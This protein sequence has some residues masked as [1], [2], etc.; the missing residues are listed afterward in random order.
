M[1]NYTLEQV[2]QSPTRWIYL[3]GRVVGFL[4]A[5][6]SSGQPWEVLPRLG[7]EAF[8]PD[9]RG[10]YEARLFQAEADALAYLGIR[11]EALA[12]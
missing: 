4:L 12:A 5:P 11:P 7:C 1:S 9:V 10:E 8:M 6:A 2:P 3:D